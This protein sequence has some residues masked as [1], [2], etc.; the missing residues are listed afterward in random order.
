MNISSDRNIK[1]ITVFY[2][3]TVADKF[4]SEKVICKKK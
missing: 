4:V 3:E 2:A 1:I